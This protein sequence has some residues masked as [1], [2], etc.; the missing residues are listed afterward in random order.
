MGVILSKGFD[1]RFWHLHSEGVGEQSI[2]YPS[3]MGGS[4]AD[5]V[6]ACHDIPCILLDEHN[7]ESSIDMHFIAM[8]ITKRVLWSNDLTF[9]IMVHI[10]QVQQF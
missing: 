9:L 2:R 8:Y 6:A 10:V 4:M 1:F 7:S 3:I 5:H